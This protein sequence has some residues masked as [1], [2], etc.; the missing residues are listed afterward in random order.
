[1]VTTKQKMLVWF[2]IIVVV[3]CIPQNDSNGSE[4]LAATTYTFVGRS[5]FTNALYRDQSTLQMTTDPPV[6]VGT[7]PPVK[8]GTDPPVKVGT[9]PPVK[10]GTDPPVKVGTDPPV[11]VGTDPPVKVGTD[12]PVKVGT[13]PPVKAGYKKWRKDWRCGR[14]FPLK[15]GRPAECDPDG[16]TPCCSP[17]NWCG[18]TADHCHCRGCVDYRKKSAARKTRTRGSDGFFTNIKNAVSFLFGR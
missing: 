13:D 5:Q 1:M 8:V 18:K 6:K 14:K 10:V 9:D 4:Q 7:D 2:S 17:G 11:K 3:G 16:V 15:D 12:P